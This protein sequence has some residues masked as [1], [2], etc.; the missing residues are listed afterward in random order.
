MSIEEVEVK[1]LRADLADCDRWVVGLKCTLEKQEWAF[2]YYER[3]CE[4]YES[5]KKTLLSRIREINKKVDGKEMLNRELTRQIE[6]L[7]RRNKLLERKNQE[8]SHQT[9]GLYLSL[10]RQIE[11][12]EWENECVELKNQQL[13]DVLKGYGTYLDNNNKKE[14]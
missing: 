6:E 14:D 2:E 5:L 12:L 8:F 3:L 4:H 1:Q 10:I 13:N 9:D 7:N 11:A